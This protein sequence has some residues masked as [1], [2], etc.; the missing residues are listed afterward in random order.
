M[1]P[2][3]LS[4]FLAGFKSGYRKEHAI[5][6]A[7]PRPVDAGPQVKKSTVVIVICAVVSALIAIPFLSP[8]PDAKIRQTMG[9][10]IPILLSQ[11]GYSW[12]ASRTEI[13]SQTALGVLRERIK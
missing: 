6:L 12:N 4:R 3:R 10:A 8:G 9:A 11:C 5:T 7:K 2:I 13:K 1:T